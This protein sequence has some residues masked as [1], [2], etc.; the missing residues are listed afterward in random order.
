[1]A[2]GPSPGD[3]VLSEL[4]RFTSRAR[5]NPRFV[6]RPLQLPFTVLS[7]LSSRSLFALFR[8]AAVTIVPPLSPLSV[9]FGQTNAEAVLHVSEAR[10]GARVPG[11][12]LITHLSLS[13]ENGC[14]NSRPTASYELLF[15]T[16]LFW[17]TRFVYRHCRLA[18]SEDVGGNNDLTEE[19]PVRHDGIKSTMLGVKS[20]SFVFPW[21]S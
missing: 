1:M 5:R 20:V 11:S 6:S 8:P 10:G 17:T 19:L 13:R 7:R 21:D 2:F 15:L 16:Y 9:V 12:H 4:F 3:P 14:E 18:G